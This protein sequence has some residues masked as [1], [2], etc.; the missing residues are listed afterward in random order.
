M[1]KRKGSRDEGSSK[2]REEGLVFVDFNRAAYSHPMWRVGKETDFP[3]KETLWLGE[4]KKPSILGRG[5]TESKNVW[6]R[7]GEWKYFLQ[8]LSI[9]TEREKTERR[10]AKGRKGNPLGGGK[11]KDA[12]RGRLKSRTSNTKILKKQVTSSC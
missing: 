10:A 11:K 3:V 2:L 5:G 12:I 9:H 4:K 8:S 1:H 6:G 7:Q